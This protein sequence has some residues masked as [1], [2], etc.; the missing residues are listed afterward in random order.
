MT[1]IEWNFRRIPDQ[2]WNDGHE[3]GTEFP[4]ASQSQLRHPE[5][6]P[7]T[8]DHLP[9]NHAATIIAIDWACLAPREARRLQELG[10]EVGEA[11]EPIHGRDPIACVIGRMTVAIGKVHA[12]AISVEPTL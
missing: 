1:V 9:L 2:F 4:I 11:V 7:H 5:G 6:V 8:L 10:F 3:P 12:A